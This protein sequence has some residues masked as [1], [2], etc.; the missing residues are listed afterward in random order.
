MILE[1][2][3]LILKKKRIFLQFSLFQNSHFWVFLILGKKHHKITKNVL[4]TAEI[5]N[6]PYYL[7]HFI[8]KNPLLDVDIFSR[9]FDMESPKCSI[10]PY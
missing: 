7:L 6:L 4:K 8:K 9:T 2:S 1:I 3:C 5:I 10:Q